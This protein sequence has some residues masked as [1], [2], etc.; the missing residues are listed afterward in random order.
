MFQICTGRRYTNV[1][2]D[3]PSDDQGIIGPKSEV[4]CLPAAWDEWGETLNCLLLQLVEQR[5]DQPSTDRRIGLSR[6]ARSGIDRGEILSPREETAGVHT[7][8]II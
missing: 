4:Y 6:V 5:D 1:Y 8:R 3:S 7:I 2:L